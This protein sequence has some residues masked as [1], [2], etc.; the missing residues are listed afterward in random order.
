MS[1][2]QVKKVDSRFDVITL[3]QQMFFHSSF[4]LGFSAKLIPSLTD[5]AI[6]FQEFSLNEQQKL[7]TF[8]YYLYPKNSN[9]DLP[10][11]NKVDLKIYASDRDC[12]T[13]KV[14]DSLH[15]LDRSFGLAISVTALKLDKFNPVF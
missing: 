3:P 5:W 11:Y 10:I 15:Y 12:F 1:I 13:G 4:K 7:F 8:S 14:T 2:T 9:T 6:T